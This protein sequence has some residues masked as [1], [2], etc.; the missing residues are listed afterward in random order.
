MESQLLSERQKLV[1]IR[2]ECV[3][4]RVLKN[5]VVLLLAYKT[6][7]GLNGCPWRLNFEKS[8]EVR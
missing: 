4:C 3:E 7:V 5:G 8:R 6:G 1:R 2:R